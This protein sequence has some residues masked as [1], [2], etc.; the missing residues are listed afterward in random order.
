MSVPTGRR[1][2]PMGSE[3]V[4]TIR[5]LAQRSA[6][7]IEP[8]RVRYDAS[9]AVYERALDA[10]RTWELSGGSTRSAS[11]RT[12]QV[13]EMTEDE[14]AWM[15]EHGGH[16]RIPYTPLRMPKGWRGRVVK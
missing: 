5:T 11:G 13:R 9:Q 14:L 4:L 3:H 15:R 8:R 1:R 10:L 16:G 7:V 6:D 2:A 12:F